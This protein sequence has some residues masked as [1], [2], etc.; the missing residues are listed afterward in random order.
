MRRTASICVILVSISLF[1]LSAFGQSNE[2]QEN[3]LNASI[4]LGWVAGVIEYQGITWD[5]YTYLSDRMS[6]AAAHVMQIAYLLEPP[7]TEIDLSGILDSIYYW[8]NQTNSMNP[9]QAVA[10]IS[11]I[12]AHLRQAMSIYYDA[13]TQRLVWD[14][15]CDSQYA[16]AGFFFGRANI[17]A[18]SGDTN[19]VSS[20]IS[21]MRQAIQ[22]GLRE[23][24]LKL[25]GFGYES[26]W[27]ALTVF[28]GDTSSASFETSREQIISIVRGSQ[29]SDNLVQD[30]TFSTF[31]SAGGAWGQGETWEENLPDW[32]NDNDAG[33]TAEIY[34]LS[35]GDYMYTQFGITTALQIT[36]PS[37]REAYHYGTTAQRI[38]ASPNQTYTVSL[39]AASSDTPSNGAVSIAVESSWGERPIT[40]P[41][42]SY[43]WTRY[44]GTFRTDSSGIIVLRILAEDVC[45]IWLTAIYVGLGN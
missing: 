9:S 23:N 13:R 28:S 34:Y 38:Q 43:G 39:W 15:T 3:I 16:A 14:T 33:S 22:V 44:E 36:N 24:E 2:M 27:N 20:N 10:Y 41:G 30:S 31:G 4:N 12:N 1:V 25:C 19:G 40:L 8:E 29:Q 6:D 37:Q 21:S 26:D 45:T 11:D 35:T 5:N 18:I 7:Y 32:W 42:G 17:A